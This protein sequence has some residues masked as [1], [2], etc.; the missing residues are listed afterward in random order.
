MARGFIEAFIGSEEENAKLIKTGLLTL[1]IALLVLRINKKESVKE[2][3]KDIVTP[4]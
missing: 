4:L 1:L 2:L 3:L